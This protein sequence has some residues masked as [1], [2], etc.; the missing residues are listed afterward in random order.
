[1]ARGFARIDDIDDMFNE[2]PKSIS[3]DNTDEELDTP[4][5][6]IDLTSVN[7]ESTRLANLVT[8]SLSDF[9]FSEEYIKEHPYIPT[10]IMLVM[11]NIR[12]L[13]KMLTVNEK[14]Q[15]A[16]ITGIA[17]NAG[18]GSL[19][20]S[21][22]ALQNSTLNIQTQLNN[23]IKELEDIF[24]KMQDECDKAFNDKEKETQEDGTITVRGAREF[25]EQICLLQ[26]KGTVDRNVK[27]EEKSAEELDKEMTMDSI[28][29]K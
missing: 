8:R 28:V 17:F 18:K 19:Y 24:Q 6:D 11:N 4:I 14:A 26:E 22:T 12:R 20:T 2:S 5:I 3:V 27:L 29:A 1:M 25:I 9:Y 16:I 15:D 7:S 10:K 13:L 21:L 23:L